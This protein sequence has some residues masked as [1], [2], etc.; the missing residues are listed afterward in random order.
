MGAGA[1]TQ[2]AD[3]RSRGMQT[4]QPQQCIILHLLLDSN[5]QE[6]SFQICVTVLSRA[7][8]A[9]SMN[10]CTQTTESIAG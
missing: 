1:A 4:L 6:S 8:T 5:Q 10:F 2:R 9:E 3:A 7:F